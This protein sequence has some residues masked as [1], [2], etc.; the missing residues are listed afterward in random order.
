MKLKTS[1]IDFSQGKS[2]TVWVKC[3]FFLEQYD[4]IRIISPKI[5]VVERLNSFGN[6]LLKENS[7][8]H[9]FIQENKNVYQ[10]IIFYVL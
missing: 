6:F 1:K 4:N 3:N 2:T 8:S 7:F 5:Q 10:I 9:S